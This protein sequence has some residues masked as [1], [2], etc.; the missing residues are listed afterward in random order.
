MRH[1]TLILKF[2]GAAVATPDHFTQIA[3]IIQQRQAQYSRLAVVVSAMGDTTDQLIALAYQ[4]HPE[5]PQREY[6]MLVTVGERVSSSLL[7][8]ALHR[9]GCEARSFTGSQ[10]GII[11]NSRHTQASI[12]D[13]RPHRILPHLDVGRVVIVAGFQ[14]VSSEG[15]ITTLGRGGSDT[16][17]VALAIALEAEHVEFYKDVEGIYSADPF[18]DPDAQFYNQLTYDQLLHLL[19]RGADVL[20]P[21]SVHLAKQHGIPLKVCSFLPGRKKEGTWVQ[22]NANREVTKFYEVALAS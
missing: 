2:G 11:T 21:R 18:V 19:G 3:Q 13:V 9:I 7:A 8:M 10:C 1:D 16:S 6:D 4:V 5:P 15:E 17:A 12:I 20:H 22:E 14:G